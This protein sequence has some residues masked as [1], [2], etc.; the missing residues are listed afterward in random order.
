MQI[1]LFKLKLGSQGVPQECRISLFLKRFPRSSTT[2]R[3]SRESLSLLNK[4]CF[5]LQPE[6]CITT[7]EPQAYIIVYSVVDRSTLQIA[8]ETLQSLWKTD[9][10]ASK[11]VILVGNKTDLVR[12][13]TVTTEGEFP[14]SKE[15]NKTEYRK[16]SLHYNRH[17]LKF[18]SRF[19]GMIF[20][21]FYLWNRSRFLCMSVFD[22]VRNKVKTAYTFSL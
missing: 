14:S 17:F 10:I 2:S 19:T 16:N 15:S 8:E 12:S 1:T 13:R 20:L 18:R 3:S 9:S 22:F 11:A 4:D 6:N 5:L 21:T 7:Y